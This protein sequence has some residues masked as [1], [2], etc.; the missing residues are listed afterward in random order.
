MAKKTKAPPVTALYT[1]AGEASGKDPESIQH[2]VNRH[3]L[4]SDLIKIG[5][6]FGHDEAVRVLAGL[7][8][9]D[10]TV[11]NAKAPA[12]RKRKTK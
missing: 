9:G 7:V 8:K 2:F 1:R 3:A 4:G 11:K 5:I 10:R 12:K 6:D